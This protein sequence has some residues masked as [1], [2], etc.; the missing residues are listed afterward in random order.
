MMDDNSSCG[1]LFVF[2]APSG[3]GKSSLVK[4]LLAA[5]PGLKLSISY[6]TRSPRPGE[7]DGREYNFI[8]QADFI[9]RRNHGE[10]LESALVHGNYYGTS[11]VWIEEQNN[12]G[13]DVIL[14]I[15]WQGALQVREKMPNTTLVFILPPS[16][17]SLDERLHKRATDSEEII[18]RRLAG[19]EAEM[20]HAPEFDYIVINDR[21]EEA[22]DAL[23]SVVKAARQQ[24]GVQMV[25][26]RELM[27]SL[28]IAV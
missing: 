18:A 7:Q 13:T 15:D 16:K 22:L 6:T 12:A 25:R 21:F 4:A 23:H 17:A 20:V 5:D 3:A 11:R 19:A 26:Q 24:T 2:S 14:E 9:A 28:G 10:F 27:S 8:S 1:R